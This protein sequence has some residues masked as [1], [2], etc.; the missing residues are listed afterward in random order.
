[1]FHVHT[2]RILL[3]HLRNRFFRQSRPCDEP[4]KRSIWRFGTGHPVN[5]RSIEWR[6]YGFPAS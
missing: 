5:D 2:T 4:Q 3:D 1:M 6:V